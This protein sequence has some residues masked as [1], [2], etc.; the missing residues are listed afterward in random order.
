MKLDWKLKGGNLLKFNC[1][2]ESIVHPETCTKMVQMDHDSNKSL[3]DWITN[4]DTTDLKSCLGDWIDTSIIEVIYTPTYQSL[5]DSN[6]MLFG[7][8]NNTP[9]RIPFGTRSDASTPSFGVF[10]AGNGFSVDNGILNVGVATSDVI[11]GI[12]T[13]YPSSGLNKAVELEPKTQ[14]AYVNLSGISVNSTIK[15]WYRTTEFSSENLP[16]TYHVQTHDKWANY[17]VEG[18][19][20]TLFN[21]VNPTES[22]KIY[23]ICQDIEG[24]MFTFVPWSDTTY[25]L[26]NDTRSGIVPNTSGVKNKSTKFLNAAGNWVA[27]PYSSLTG[28]PTVFTTSDNGFVPKS[29]NNTTK[30]L[31]GDGQWAMPNAESSRS[32]YNLILPIS[33]ATWDSLVVSI[34]NDIQMAHDLETGTSRDIQINIVEAFTDNDKTIYLLCQMISDLF[35]E[36]IKKWENN[37]IGFNNYSIHFT[38]CFILKQ[39]TSASVKLY[40][41]QRGPNMPEYTINI[42]GNEFSRYNNPY[43]DTEDGKYSLNFELQALQDDTKDINYKLDVKIS[44]VQFTNQLN[45][46]DWRWAM[47]VNTIASECSKI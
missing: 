1:N 21:N 41:H 15:S 40:V 27:V 32:V 34:Q 31:R 37:T 43:I 20:N 22:S 23:P 33:N 12:K 4:N 26:F 42:S 2:K 9:V 36:V 17:K 10:K 28:L 3:Y 13:G 7:T 24:K 18:S 46:T 11:G 6:S 44:Q 38:I 8:I 39:S 5:D 19:F 35:I 29:G 14:Q 30:Y 47:N 45:M 25:G 16:K